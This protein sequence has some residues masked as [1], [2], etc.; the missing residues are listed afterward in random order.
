MS[1][2]LD[3]SSCQKLELENEKLRQK[4]EY[5]KEENEDLEQKNEDLQQQLAEM[6]GKTVAIT[7]RDQRGSLDRS[8]TK[9]AGTK[10]ISRSPTNTPQSTAKKPRFQPKTLPNTENSY[11]QNF[12]ILEIYRQQSTF[13]VTSE[14]DILF[15]TISDISELPESDSNI[16]VE[17][18]IS[19][20]CQF[21]DPVNPLDLVDL[22]DPVPGNS[23]LPFFLSFSRHFRHFRKLA[24]EQVSRD[25][26]EN[27]PGIF[28]TPEPPTPAARISK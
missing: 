4:I 26:L 25:L 5:L 21:V 27:P 7:P 18:S 28:K 14:T 24:R 17:P 12:G 3:C 6:A 8:F 9:T 15:K 22:E 23:I 20:S 10:R 1:Q 13:Q 19:S 11:N 16:T 2:Q